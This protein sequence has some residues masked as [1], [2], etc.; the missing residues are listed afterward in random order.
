MFRRDLVVSGYLF[1]V[2]FLLSVGL[3]CPIVSAQNLEVFVLSSEQ[4]GRIRE[5]LQSGDLVYHTQSRSIRLSSGQIKDSRLAQVSEYRV[6]LET[7][8]GPPNTVEQ[9]EDGK[10]VVVSPSLQGTKD[11]TD[12]EL[13]KVSFGKYRDLCIVCG[14][15]FWGSYVVPEYGL[16]YALNSSLSIESS[17]LMGNK[18]GGRVQNGTD[19][20]LKLPKNGLSGVPLVVPTPPK[21]FKIPRVYPESMESSR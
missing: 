19:P 10:I 6:F 14:R 4:T 15:N 12:K 16:G 5:L 7:M 20:S 8:L 2:V 21:V 18:P 3:G 17:R 9:R 1:S 11:Q 13:V